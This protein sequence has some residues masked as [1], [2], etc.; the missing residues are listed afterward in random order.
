MSVP[1]GNHLLSRQLLPSILGNQIQPLWLET[2]GGRLAIWCPSEA[3]L[4]VHNLKSGQGGGR[5]LFRRLC[6]YQFL[7]VHQH[8]ER[9]MVPVRL[10]SNQGMIDEPDYRHQWGSS[11]CQIFQS[12]SNIE[13]CVARVSG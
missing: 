1:Q 9:V 2:Y 7:E 10:M 3:Q 12:D 11:F 13:R 5:R 6:H 8:D 4:E